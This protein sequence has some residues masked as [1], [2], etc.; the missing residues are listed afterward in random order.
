MQLLHIPGFLLKGCFIYNKL[1]PIHIGTHTAFE[2]TLFVAREKK[3][4]LSGLY[5]I[6]NVIRINYHTYLRSSIVAN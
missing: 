2:T 4:V 5:P 1:E 3:M 6:N